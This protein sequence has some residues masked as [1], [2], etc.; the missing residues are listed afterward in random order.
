MIG[1]S[2]SRKSGTSGAGGRFGRFIL[3]MVGNGGRGGK[4]G[5]R[6]ISRGI[7]VALNEKLVYKFPPAEISIF[8]KRGSFIRGSFGHLKSTMR[9]SKTGT[10]NS[11]FKFISLKSRSTSG[12]VGKSI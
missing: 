3:G 11:K 7:A 1:K 5:G 6:G 9:T 2:A 4:S 8:S 12:Q 10:T